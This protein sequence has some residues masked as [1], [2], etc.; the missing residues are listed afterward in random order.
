[1][2]DKSIFSRIIDREIP[3]HIVYEDEFCIAFLDVRPL[4]KGHTLVVPKKQ[5]DKFYHIEKNVLEHVM[6][7]SKKIARALENTVPCARVGMAI[8]GLEVPHTHLHLVPINESKDLDFSNPNR[9]SMEEGEILNLAKNL[10]EE[11][12]RINL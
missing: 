12:N 5:I 11:I 8:I 6:I 9:L 4:Q 7:V 2:T 1:M 3:A 10:E